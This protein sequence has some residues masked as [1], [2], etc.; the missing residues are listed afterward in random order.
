VP[1]ANSRLLL[2]K[3]FKEPRRAKAEKLGADQV[4]CWELLQKL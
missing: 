2:S 4:R 3:Y 1:N